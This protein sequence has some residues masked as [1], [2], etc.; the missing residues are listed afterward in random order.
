MGVVSLAGPSFSISGLWEGLYTCSPS[1]MIDVRRGWLLLLSSVVIIGLLY[2]VNAWYTGGNYASLD[3]RAKWT[4]L[5][6]SNI[7]ARPA[8][9]QQQPL[10]LLKFEKELPTGGSA[11][12]QQQPLRLLNLEEESPTRDSTGRPLRFLYLSQTEDCLPNNLLT[13]DVIGNV[14]A[15]RCDVLVL[16]YK[17]RCNE[18]PHKHVEYLFNS[19]TSTSWASGRNLLYEN[20]KKRGRVYLYYIFLDDDVSLSSRTPNTNP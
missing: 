7:Q 2:W 12:E 16:S 15:C 11:T 1:S 5:G 3:R 4:I 18:N 13:G 19:N 17:R 9:E 6:A 10:R 8:T 20:A 14:T